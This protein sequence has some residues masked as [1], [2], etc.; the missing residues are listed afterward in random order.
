MRRI[1]VT[2]I[3]SLFCA[4]LVAA[5]ASADFGFKEL[6]L[7]A[8]EFDGT[9]AMEAGSHPFAFTT[10]IEVKT[11]TDP[12]TGEEVPEGAFRDLTAELP[13]GLVGT[14]NPVPFCSTVDFLEVVE[15]YSACPDSTAIGVSAAGA[16]FHGRGLIYSPVY[17]LAPPPGVAAKLGFVALEIPVTV[18]VRVKQEHPYNLVAEVTDT[19]Q[20]AYFYGSKLTLWGNPADPV[21][22]PLRGH[23]IDILGGTPEEIQSLGD[24]PVD[25]PEKAF[26]TL[27][28]SCTGPLTMN[29]SGVAWN[30]GKTTSGSAATPDSMVGCSKLVLDPEVAA[31]PT[32]DQ[33]ESSSGL[34]F[35]LDIRDEGLL[36]PDRPAQ[37]SDI[38]RAVVTLPPGVTANPSLAE[39]LAACSRAD[40]ERER[41]DVEGCPPAS[42]IGAVE[43]E[44]PLLEGT[45]LKGQVFV[46]SQDDNPFGSLL[47]LYMVIKEPKLGIMVKLPGRV[48]PDPRTGQLVTTFGDAPYEIPQFPFSHFRFRFRQGARAPL[49]TPPACG[50]YTIQ[51]EFIPWADP[52]KRIP[53][54]ASF[55]ISRGVGGSLCPS[56][57]PPFVPGFE[58]GAINNNA[59]SFAPYFLRLTRRDGDQTLTRFS[60]TLPPGSLAKLVGV[61]Q[62]TDAQIAAARVKTGR[63]EQ[64][65]SSCPANAQ[66]GRVLAGAG[67]G[68][69][70]TYVPGKVYL[71]GPLNGAPLSVV[72]IVPAVAGPF[73]LGTVVTR[74]ALTVDPRTG[75]AQVDGA[76]SDPIPQILEGIP[77]KV[78]DVRVYIDRPDFTLNPTSCDPE[79]FKAQLWGSSADPVS[80]STRFQAANCSKLP[81]KPKLSLKLSGGTK[82]GDHPALRSVLRFPSRPRNANVRKAV[83]ALPPTEFIDNAHIQSPCTRVQFNADRCPRSSLLGTARAFTPLLEKPLEGP[84]YFRSNGGERLL[85]DVVADLRGQF[86]IVLVGKVDSFHERI[87]TTFA[88]VPDAPVSKFTLNLKGGKS[89]L[90]VNNRNLC[91]HR[92]HAIVDFTGQNGKVKHLTPVVANS[93]FRNVKHK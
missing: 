35:Q 82:R 7:S 14:P 76:R 29:F 41:A 50:S 81:F 2:L 36:D 18:E 69:Q 63:Q 15:G 10:R 74:Q 42:K 40:F 55:G 73:D 60:T 38:K 34:D 37:Q 48:D 4:L 49:V 11:T 52:S 85:P 84:V 78:R 31:Q 66:I 90:L 89:G 13:P 27:P 26:L 9:P 5:P 47:A 57:G 17:N 86:H 6:G 44:T 3:A 46:A 88:G 92:S 33:A 45:L 25:T 8:T 16:G 51:A 87:R 32:T 43:V 75:V 93:C 72:A 83:V 68:S 61:S 79:A 21:H 30:T 53:A 19:P 59:A 12:D 91:T 1:L 80:L 28:R 23:C 70:L 71:A 67:V 39:G 58:A 54:N 65:F 62:C 56:G 64:A 20:S 22:D 77:L 24:C